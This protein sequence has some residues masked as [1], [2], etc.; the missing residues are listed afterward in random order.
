MLRTDMQ[1]F[2]KRTQKTNLTI[3]DLILLDF[4]ALNGSCNVNL[5]KIDNY[6]VHMNCSYSHNIPDDQIENKM[7]ELI[8]KGW[9]DKKVGDVFDIGFDTQ[10]AE[11]V[12][13]K[14]QGYIYSIA[15]KGGVLWE[16]ERTP[17]W[18][19]YCSDFSYPDEINEN[20]YYFE[21]DCLT[22]DIG[23][24]FAQ[25]T[26][27]CGLYKYEFD[28]LKPTAPDPDFV[29]WKKFENV[30]AWKAPLI[31]SNSTDVDW[32]YY[33]TIRTWWRDLDELQK[34]IA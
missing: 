34:F 13:S 21:L 2:P 29:N 33:E 10:K 19:K 11:Y 23:L 22:K 26:V 5:L 27:D 1:D 17:M 32:D 15:Q 3:D 7:E 20:L 9:V 24:Q 8:S 30:F 6:P 28:K 18:E 14:S 16:I 31:D 25:S 4:L 12:F